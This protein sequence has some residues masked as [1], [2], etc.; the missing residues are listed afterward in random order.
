MMKMFALSIEE[1]SDPKKACEHSLPTEVWIQICFNFHC[2][3]M[4]LLTE[5]KLKLMNSDYAI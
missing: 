3:R 5:K 4:V 1:L 2:G